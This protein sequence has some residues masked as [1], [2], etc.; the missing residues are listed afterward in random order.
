[1]QESIVILTSLKIPCSANNDNIRVLIENWR[2]SDTDHN[3]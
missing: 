2:H 3:L 1:M